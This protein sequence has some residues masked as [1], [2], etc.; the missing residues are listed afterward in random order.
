MGVANNLVR[1]ISG[2][3]LGLS[4][5]AGAARG[6]HAD[7]Q[8]PAP[9][10]AIRV[11]Q[12]TQRTSFGKEIRV[13]L[14]AESDA[15][16][17]VAVKGW[18][19]PRG[20]DRISSYTYPE[21]RPG[22]TVTASFSIKTGE[23]AYYPPGTDFDYHFELTDSAGNTFETPRQTVEYLDPRF[24]WKRQARGPL[25][26]VYYNLPDDRVSRLLDDAAADLPRLAR[27]TGADAS[28][29]YKAVLYRTVSEA[30][31][32]FPRVSETATDRQFF[33]GFA[34]SEYGLFVLGEPAEGTFVHELTH[35][36]VG[37]AVDSPLAAP[38][39]AWLNEGLA[40][41]SEGNDTAALNA[42]IRSAAGSGRLLKLRAMNSIPGRGPEIG[43]FYPQAG[44]FVGYL[45]TRFG[46]DGLAALLR[47]IN[48]GRKVYDAAKDVW[49]VSLD[50]VENDWRASLGAQ[51]LPTP[52]PTAP[53]EPSPTAPATPALA[54]EAP[55]PPV[56]TTPSPAPTPAPAPT[57]GPALP[58]VTSPSVQAASSVASSSFWAY[59]LVAAAAG[60]LLV[61]AA[62]VIRGARR[63]GSV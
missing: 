26:A 59:I 18:F 21:F 32:A 28:E 5:L 51:P 12:Q 30:T 50:D 2:L 54:A 56:S 55:A 4:V 33:A 6:A 25:T 7:T 41:F 27:M 3:L 63:G 15:G 13:T 22:R 52:S 42:R 46:P 35:L 39:P 45:H 58:T 57:P 10:S 14:Q 47:R 61:A 31:S 62:G 9:T 43:T 17:I 48:E 44:A 49:S 53:P 1:A 23:S 38:V 8:T 34:Q 20:P 40:T 16:E 60:L 37:Q 24:T 11:I 36:L 19:R 29:P